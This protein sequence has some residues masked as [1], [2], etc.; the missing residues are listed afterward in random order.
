MSIRKI[1]V[2]ED[3][4][5]LHRMYELILLPYRRNGSEVLHAY[6]GRE[7]LNLLGSN[8]DVELIILDI[9]MPVMSGLEFLRCLQAED[10]FKN[11]PVI[12]VTTEGKEDDTIR[13]LKAGARGYVAKPFQAPDLY[14][15]IERV[16]PE[17]SV[18]TPITQEN[19]GS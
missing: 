1:L 8:P 16:L 9:N 3:S 10:A 17:V 5:L 2:V 7:G 15:I 13:G 6:N 12:I 19:R 11:I 18:G 4:E 14:R